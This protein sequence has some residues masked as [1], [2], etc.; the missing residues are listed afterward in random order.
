MKIGRSTSSKGDSVVTTVKR[1]SLNIA[2]VPS[3]AG[4]HLSI[5]HE[6]QPE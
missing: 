5:D 4:K 3:S 2:I 6:A 1:G